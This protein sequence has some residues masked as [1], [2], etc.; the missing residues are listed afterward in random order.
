[1]NTYKLINRLLVILFVGFV[2][3]LLSPL[4]PFNRG[5]RADE[6]DVHLY[7]APRKIKEIFDRAVMY[8]DEHGRWPTLA[9]LEKEGTNFNSP[10]WEYSISS[11]YGESFTITLT[12]KEGYS[13]KGEKGMV[14]QPGDFMAI[15]VN[16][17]MRT[18]SSALK[19][20][21][22]LKS[23]LKDAVLVEGN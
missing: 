14:I 13:V 23:Y 21:H 19:N 20:N 6:N 12:V 9:K 3:Y 22:F 1:M 18:N 2:A 11:V 4:S 15:S 10:F 16:G 5:L 17:D 7:S 8:E